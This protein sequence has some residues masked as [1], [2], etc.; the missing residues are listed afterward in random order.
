MSV[1]LHFTS[2]TASPSA[3]SERLASH[4]ASV[5][6]STL[7]RPFGCGL[8]LSPAVLLAHGG[9]VP[10]WRC[11]MN[12]NAHDTRVEYLP[13]EADILSQAENILRKR[14]ERLGTLTDPMQAGDF[15][16]MRMGGLEHEEFHVL[17]LDVK[18]SIIAVE[19]M[20]RGTIDGAEIHPREVAR[21]AL[22]HNAAAVVLAHN[23]PSSGNPEPSVADRA[24]TVRLQQALELIQVRVLDHIVV[25]EKCVSFAERGWI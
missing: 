10:L 16:R 19:V 12:S 3:A 14:L 5:R 2:S 23:H 6:C 9:A 11:V 13:I 20:F 21:A 4:P 18:H 7:F 25:G 8:H 22:K 17:F 24:I 15:L 1:A